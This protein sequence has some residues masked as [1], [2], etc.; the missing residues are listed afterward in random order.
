MNSSVADR[1][2]TRDG[3]GAR[4]ILIA[5]LRI[6]CTSFGGPIA[7]FGYFHEEF[8]ARRRW[9]EDSQ[10]GEIIALGAFLLLVQG[11]VHP[12]KVVLATAAAS[13]LLLH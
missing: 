1:A 10:F 2:S 4:T 5:F 6:G 11:R 13:A 8:V 3:V 9:L 12:W 7:H